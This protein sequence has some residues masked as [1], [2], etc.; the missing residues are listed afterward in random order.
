MLIIFK[1][2][3]GNNPPLPPADISPKAKSIDI[4]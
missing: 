2:L 3:N 4:S 1:E